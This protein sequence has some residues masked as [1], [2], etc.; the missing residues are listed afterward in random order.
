LSAACLQA[1]DYLGAG[2]A[3]GGAPKY[4]L[5][6]KRVNE[7]IIPAAGSTLASKLRIECW[8]SATAWL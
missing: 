3:A 6:M 5:P 4:R 8:I 2:G 1:G 7:F